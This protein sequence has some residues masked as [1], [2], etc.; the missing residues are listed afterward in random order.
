MVGYSLEL[1]M[2]INDTNMWLAKVQHYLK[3]ILY[4]IQHKFQ[5]GDENM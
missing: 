2:I 5:D 4:W 1:Y 3:Q